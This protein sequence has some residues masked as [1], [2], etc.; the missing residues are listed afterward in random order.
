M[1]WDI[2]DRPFAGKFA[3]RSISWGSG[4]VAPGDGTG[5]GESGSS[6]QWRGNR[7]PKPREISVA[8][9]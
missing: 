5:K 9:Y 7:A 1:I 3:N 6:T 2:A 4:Q 8:R